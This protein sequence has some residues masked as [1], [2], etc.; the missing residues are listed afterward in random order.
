MTVKHQEISVL[1]YGAG[2]VGLGIASCLL[3]AGLHPVLIARPHTANPLQQEG[4][5][6]KGIFGD[7]FFPPSSFSVSTSIEEILD[8]Q[9]HYILVCTK[10]S[11]TFASAKKLSAHPNLLKP[12]G[13]IV[14][15]Q[16]GWGNAEIFGNFFSKAIIF[17]ARV[18]TGFIRTR[19][20]EVEITVHADAI[21]IGSLFGESTAL[22][23]PLCEAIRIGGIPCETTDQIGEDLWAKML[24]NCALNPLG[25]VLDVSYGEL[26]DHPAA[27][28]IMDRLIEETFDAMQSE[29]CRTH[30][31]NVEDFKTDFYGKLVPS[32]AAHRSSTLQ[33]LK[34]G[35]TT[36]ID[37]LTGAVLRLAQKH[38]RPAPYSNFLYQL[39]RF[40]E[41]R[42]N[43][44]LQDG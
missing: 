44:N 7:A 29:G 2:A 3:K 28:E 24:Y 16:N 20:N 22:V 35:K 14:L 8:N 21:H 6:R 9:F 27:R 26:A 13:L 36:E 4:L 42:K 33:D 34:A 17:N 41:A 1:I 43:R 25:A 30:W 38:H 11:D 19:P 40:I 12:N 37:A 18:I 10:S 15:F 39:I 32:T 23:S 31:K 5:F